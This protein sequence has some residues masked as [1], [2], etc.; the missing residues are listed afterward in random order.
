MIF[1]FRMLSDENDN[2]LREYEVPYDMTLLELH[3]FICRDLKYDP[4]NMVSFFL[5]DLRLEG[6]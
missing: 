2:F 4:D 1:K 5:S 3:R 6:I